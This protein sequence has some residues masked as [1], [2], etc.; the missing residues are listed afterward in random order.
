[1]EVEKKLGIYVRQSVKKEK[2]FSIEDQ[3]I[4]GKNK[5]DELGWG[6]EYYIDE[7]ISAFSDNTY[8]PEY[9]RLINDI[10]ENRISGVFVKDISRLTRNMITYYRV[11]SL[12]IEKNITIFTEHDGDLNPTDV[13]SEIFMSIKTIFNNNYIR[14]TSL[15]I[16]S[17]LQ[18][19]ALNGKAPT[20]PNLPYGFAKDENNFLIIDEV[21]SKIIKLIYQ[22]HS[23]GL[24]IERIAQFL[25]ENNVKTK[26]NL[27]NKNYSLKN[28]YSNTI[29]KKHSSTIS[30]SSGVIHKIL[31]NPIYMGRRMHKG[32]EIPSPI[33]I[34]ENIWNETQIRLKERKNNPGPKKHQYLLQGLVFCERC[35]NVFV[36]KIKEQ[37]K[38]FTYSC[39]SRIKKP[40]CGNKGIN[41]YMF[42]E[43]VL[44]MILNSS[45]A[46]DA[47]HA[48]INS[49][50]EQFTIEDLKEKLNKLNKEKSKSE[51]YR[52][53]LLRKFKEDLISETELNEF[54]KESNKEINELTMFES[55]IKSILDNRTQVYNNFSNLEEVIREMALYGT[56]EEKR[57]IV[58][59]RVQK[60]TINY[61]SEID[62]FNIN[63][64]LKTNKTLNY[65]Y[66]RTDKTTFFPDF[67][68]PP[69][70]TQQLM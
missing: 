45:Y 37:K 5:A 18:T 46:D 8:R 3:K 1:M 49:N 11:T 28:K 62:C 66:A 12:A 4:S 40:N 21:E 44:Y 64:I 47:I 6:Y 2:G 34:D 36:G 61:E 70:S 10:Q 14:D 16:K 69:N 32:I 24:G 42:D 56:H 67:N 23:D 33:I 15:K 22:K 41:L 68:S 35:G 48:Y 19:R 9:D 51:N 7:G 57:K 30:W 50:S 29:K 60:I 53:T 20:G 38:E 17:S 27:L 59:D 39:S 55:E 31:T 58:T 65:V 43:L 54:L 25:N 63:I 13:T 26:T 52:K